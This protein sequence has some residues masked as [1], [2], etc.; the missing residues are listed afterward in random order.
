M[1]LDISPIFN[2]ASLMPT[3]NSRCHVLAAWRVPYKHRLSL[4]HFLARVLA[5]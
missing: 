5:S 3:S 4:P 1:H 2:S